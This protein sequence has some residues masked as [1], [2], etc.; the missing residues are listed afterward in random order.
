MT[1]KVR[2]VQIHWVLFLWEFQPHLY[3]SSWLNFTLYTIWW[4]I[5][6]LCLRVRPAVINTSWSNC[7]F[8]EWT[9]PVV[10]SPPFLLSFPGEQWF[11]SLK[12]SI[13]SL[14]FSAHFLSDPF[15]SESLFGHYHFLSHKRPR[16]GPS[17]MPGPQ[18]NPGRISTGWS[19]G[20]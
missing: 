20:S 17:W 11:T 1:S 12:W 8:R 18:Q 16:R 3:G 4:G 19:L 14:T 9:P 7:Q 6:I 13:T 10:A 2:T 5:N 15:L